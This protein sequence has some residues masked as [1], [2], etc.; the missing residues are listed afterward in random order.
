MAPP[1]M[2]DHSATAGYSAR[3]CECFVF[4]ARCA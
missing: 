2:I 3:M 1:K 4:E